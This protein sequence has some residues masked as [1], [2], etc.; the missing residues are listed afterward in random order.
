MVNPVVT[1]IRKCSNKIESPR[2]NGEATKSEEQT[3]KN[4]IK[5]TEEREQMMSENERVAK[6]ISIYRR[7]NHMLKSSKI[8]NRDGGAVKTT[9]RSTKY[10][11]NN[12]LL[13]PFSVCAVDSAAVAAVTQHFRAKIH[14]CNFKINTLHRMCRMLDNLLCEAAIEQSG[15]SAALHLGTCFSCAFLFADDDAVGCYSLNALALLPYKC[16]LVYF[17][18]DLRFSHWQ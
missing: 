5:T 1:L 16:K 4:R 11:A 9:Q 15:K 7:K 10:R 2:V 8:E 13:G 3:T 18:I 17:L 6:L 12:Q 14:V